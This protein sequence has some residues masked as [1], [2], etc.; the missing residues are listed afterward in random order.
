MAPSVNI[1]E[2][3]SESEYLEISTSKQK[4]RNNDEQRQG[5]VQ[6]SKQKNG[7]KSSESDPSKSNDSLEKLLSSHGMCG[8]FLNASKSSAI[9]DNSCT[10]QTSVGDFEESDFKLTSTSS[11]HARYEEDS[12][13][14]DLSIHF[15]NST[16]IESSMMTTEHTT[17]LVQSE[18]EKVDIKHVSNKQK[19]ETS[20]KK[21]TKTEIRNK[22]M[23]LLPRN[24]SGALLP[25]R[26]GF[27]N[28]FRKSS[29]ERLKETRKPKQDHAVDHVERDVA[30]R[31][32]QLRRRAVSFD[33][34]S[35]FSR[36]DM[37]V[38]MV[39]G[40]SLFAG[41]EVTLFI[42][43]QL[44]TRTLAGWLK[45]RNERATSLPGM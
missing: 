27:R 12:E 39:S 32:N 31:K 26:F 15:E 25:G 22:N 28:L 30:F 8:S 1:T 6:S 35:E 20:F 40:S 21:E 24:N 23:E 10:E 34:L 3:E 38:G 45:E 41:L 9:T 17:S 7:E 44:C 14:S 4:A 29:R 33:P 5:A 37:D 11:M 42:Q 36:G 18:S 19:V 2:I 16:H 43:M 13:M